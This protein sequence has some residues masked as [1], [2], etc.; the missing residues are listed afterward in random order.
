LRAAVGPLLTGVG[1]VLLN[2]RQGS[3]VSPDSG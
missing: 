2:L 3:G 1:L